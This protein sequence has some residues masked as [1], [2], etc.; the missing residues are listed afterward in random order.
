MSGTERPAGAAPR[1]QVSPESSQFLTVD[2]TKRPRANSD[3][4]G[5]HLTLIGLPEIT[6]TGEDGQDSCQGE[7]GDV[8]GLLLPPSPR[9]RA[10]TCPEDMFRPRKGRPPTPPPS[11]IMKNPAGKRFSFNF[12]P[13][14]LNGISFIHHKLGKLTEDNSEPT[15]S[16][17]DEVCLGATG[18]EESLET[19]PRLGQSEPN[20]HTDHPSSRKHGAFSAGGKFSK[21]SNAASITS[22]ENALSQPMAGLSVSSPSG[23]SSEVSNNNDVGVKDIGK[24]SDVTKCSSDSW[25]SKDSNHESTDSSRLTAC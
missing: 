9:R 3:P 17:A 19:N 20:G 23:K 16:E 5:L 8:G 7:E 21:H 2:E 14:D 13:K 6:V 25:R 11:D 24:T 15:P 10:N 18:G 1:L 12:T 4:L 22:K